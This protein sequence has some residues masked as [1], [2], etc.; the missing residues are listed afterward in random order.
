MLIWRVAWLLD[1]GVDAQ[2]DSSVAKVF[3]SEA[4]W[5][6]VDRAIQ[7]CGSLGVSGDAPLA[8]LMGEVRPFRIYDGASEA[9]RWSIARREVRGR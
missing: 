9:H 2:R 7:I 8:R 3:V 5:R 6:I 4:V 1:E